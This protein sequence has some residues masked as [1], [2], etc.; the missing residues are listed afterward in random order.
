[1]RGRSVD[2]LKT[3]RQLCKQWWI[4]ARQHGGKAVAKADF[5]AAAY[6]TMAISRTDQE[7]SEIHDYMDWPKA[8]SVYKTSKR[9]KAA[10]KAGTLIKRQLQDSTGKWHNMYKA[11]SFQGTLRHKENGACI[12]TKKQKRCPCTGF[13]NIPNGTLVI[14]QVI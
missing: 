12:N 8:C 10:L 1:M 11:L 9:A 3:L 14:V 6:T 13:L 5:E 7:V 2:K 4:G